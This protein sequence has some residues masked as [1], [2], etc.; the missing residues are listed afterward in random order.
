M[1]LALLPQ[2]ALPQAAEP[3]TSTQKFPFDE[4]GFWHQP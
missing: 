2:V 1:Y 4:A 3:A